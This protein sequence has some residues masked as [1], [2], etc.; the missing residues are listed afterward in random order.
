[1]NQAQRNFLIKKIEESAKVRTEAL[2]SSI[3]N[4]PSLNN[5]L[6]HAVMSNN[7]EIKTT[8]QLKEMVRQMALK[9]K[10]RDDWMGNSWGSANKSAIHF[11]AK[12]FFNVPEEYQKLYNAYKEKRKNAEDEMYSIQVQADTLITRIQLASDK[13][14]QTMIN[15]VDDMGNISLMDAKLKL[16][17]K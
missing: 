9:A 15:E 7:F 16:L 8:E 5:Y 4:A 3:P 11:D 12:D 14:L 2:R 17:T 13:I 1:M 10:D 6:L